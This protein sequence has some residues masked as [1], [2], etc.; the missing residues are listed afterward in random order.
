VS[1]KAEHKYHLVNPSPLPAL[2]ALALFILAIGGVMFMHEYRFGIPTLLAGFAS[3]ASVMAYWWYEVIREGRI[4][5]AHSR[6]VRKGL[7]LGMLLFIIS[8]VMF[9]FVFFWSFFNSSL[10]PSDILNGEVW[11][12]KKGVWPPEG[13]KLLD[14]WNIPF[15]NTLILLLSGTTVTW[16]HHA[17]IDNKQ[18]ELV[19]ALSITVGLGVV[20][21]LLQMYEYHHA[22]FHWKDGI[23]ASN[24]YMITG[25]HGA[26]V[27]IGTI[28]LAVCLYRARDGHFAEGRGHLGFEFA[29]WYWHFVDV[30]W[31]FLFVFVYVMGG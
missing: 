22:E 13:I 15:L 7:S 29:A 12:V 8:E 21:S 24:F 26:H 11:P 25:F 2:A 16:A 28:F 20:F 14:A 19:K 10:F 30:I 6:V 27:I 31:L 18:E 17:L 9:F 1:N 3:I 23:F 4:D 5:M